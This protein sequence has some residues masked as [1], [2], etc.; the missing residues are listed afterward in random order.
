MIQ[1]F[2]LTS[3]SNFIEIVESKEKNN[4]VLFRGQTNDDKLL[5]KIARKNPKVDTIKT[6]IAMI[7]ELRRRSNEFVQSQMKTDWDW[8]AL[9]QHYG[10]TTRLL[11]WTSNPL[12]ALW[13]ACNSQNIKADHSVLWIYLVP[14]DA[15]LDTDTEKTPFNAGKTRVYQPNLVGKRLSTQSGWF[16]AHKFS[17]TSTPNMFV[18]FEN[19]TNQRDNLIK[20]LIPK[21]LRSKF[22]EVIDTC[23]IN[24]STVFPELDGLCKHINWVHLGE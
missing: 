8:L 19:N 10:L 18:P 9:G 5:P 11:D 22:V 2:T 15:I 12:I 3:F 7:K 4:L 17:K 1:K 16:T 14:D 23:G 24:A 20:V 6:E 21:K 13:F